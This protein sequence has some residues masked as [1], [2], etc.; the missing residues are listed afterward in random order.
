MVLNETEKAYDL[1]MAKPCIY[2]YPQ[3][4]NMYITLL[5]S[6]HYLIAY[7]VKAKKAKT[8]R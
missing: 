8:Y 1:V 7:Q 2:V 4:A 5:I 6:I 3:R